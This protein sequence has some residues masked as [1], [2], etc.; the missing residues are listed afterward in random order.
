VE[1]QTE[2]DAHRCEDNQTSALK[3]PLADFHT[4]DFPPRQGDLPGRGERYVYVFCWKAN[5][6]DVPFYV[7]QTNRLQGRMDD[8]QSAQFAAST[9]FRVGKAIRYLRDQRSLRIVVRYK[10]SRDSVKDEYTLIRD[11][12]LSGLRLLNSLP[13]YDYL[14]A[15]KDEERRTVQRFCEMLMDNQPR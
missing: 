3:A 5:G 1:V 15:D 6:K 10:E 7:G 4:V 2:F 9:D 12:Q 14:K 8:Y 11:L 13:G